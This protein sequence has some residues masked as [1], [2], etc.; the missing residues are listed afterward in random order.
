MRRV[1]VS[2]AQAVSLP[3]YC[4]VRPK[5]WLRSQ[6][7]AIRTQGWDRNTYRTTEQI[8]K[9]LESCL[10]PIM[11]NLSFAQQLNSEANVYSLAPSKHSAGLFVK[12][13]S[14]FD[15]LD[16]EKIDR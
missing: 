7:K 12:P 15:P 14:I 1:A 3:Y 9:S 6:P 4:Q 10:G 11:Q 8:K 13:N 2:K 5:P 16:S